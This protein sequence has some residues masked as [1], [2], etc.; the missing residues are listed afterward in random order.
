VLQETGY[1][2]GMD[3]SEK[4]IYLGLRGLGLS[5]REARAGARGRR[6]LL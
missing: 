1:T 3:E 5:E 2:E 6:R 4:E